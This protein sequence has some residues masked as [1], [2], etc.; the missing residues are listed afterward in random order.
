[1]TSMPAGQESGKGIDSRVRPT[2]GDPH[3]GGRTPGEQGTDSASL[4]R[5]GT[6]GLLVASLVISMRTGAEERRSLVLE[7][8]AAS[9]S[10]ALAGGVLTDFHLS[11]DPVNPL[12]GMGHFLCLDRWGPPSAA[13]AKNG[14]PFHGEAWKVQW[15][16]TRPP[17]RRGDAT[18]AEM[19]AA[20]PLAGLEVRRRIRM[21]DHEPLV[22]V[23]E[24]V[25]NRNRLGRIF[26]IVQHPTI[27]PPFLDLR[28]RVDA[29]AGKGF[30]QSSPLPDP[31]RPEVRWPHALYQGR[32]VDLRH[33]AD[34]PEPNVVSYVMRG[35]YGWTTA[36]APITSG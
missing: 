19:A 10:V 26:N 34:D 30:M 18:E 32:K 24:E 12:R 16:L 31:E 5:I 36:C 7:G 14:M 4:R 28:T 6:I 9:L 20:L 13:E 1:M 33:L 22:L 11:G 8:Q 15:S 25:T 17:E 21:L 27:G 2:A 3:V 29:G 23:R 35:R